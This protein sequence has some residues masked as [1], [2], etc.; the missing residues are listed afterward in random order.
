M[1]QQWP[2]KPITDFGGLFHGP[3]GESFP[4]HSVGC[5]DSTIFV[6]A[7]VLLTRNGKPAEKV[8]RILPKTPA[9]I[10]QPPRV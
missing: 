2:S 9:P 10:P 3:K 1:L 4:Q 8:G 6:E 5:Q 7:I